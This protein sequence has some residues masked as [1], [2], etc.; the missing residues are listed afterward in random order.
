MSFIYSLNPILQAL[1]ATIFTWSVTAMGAALVFMFKKTHKKKRNA[2]FSYNYTQTYTI[3]K[4]L[5]V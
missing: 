1:L 4:Y 2:T 3:T 5:I